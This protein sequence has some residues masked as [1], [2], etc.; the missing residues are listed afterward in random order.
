MFQNL[1]VF[2]VSHDMAVHA[3]NRQAVLARN[4]ANADTPG[5]VAKDV[6]PF[7]AALDTSRSDTPMRHTRETHLYPSFSATPAMSSAGTG[8]APNGNAVSLEEEMLK[9]VDTKRQ[10]DRALAIYKS[11]LSVLRTSLGRR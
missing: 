5:Y 7:Q 9:A 11:S 8:H 1:N 4:M 3:A 10:H 2:K 6:A